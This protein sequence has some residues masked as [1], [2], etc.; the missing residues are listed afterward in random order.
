MC[1]VHLRCVDSRSLRSPEY[2]V[3]HTVE[4]NSNNGLMCVLNR[5]I[6]KSL[7]RQ[8]VDFSR[9]FARPVA[10][11]T[12]IEMWEWNFRVLST[13]M[14]KSLCVGWMERSMLSM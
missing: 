8:S 7:S 9:L 2:P 1:L 5:V 4:P 3:F 14:P 10:F 6:K 12:V 11:F 13:I